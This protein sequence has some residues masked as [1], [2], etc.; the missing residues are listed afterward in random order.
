MSEVTV[1]EFVGKKYL[2]AQD[3]D[4]AFRAVAEALEGGLDAEN[5]SGRL[6]PAQL[7]QPRSL[8]SFSGKGRSLLMSEESLVVGWRL[9]RKKTDSEPSHCALMLSYSKKANA[10]DA[11]WGFSHSW[12]DEFGDDGL[13]HFALDYRGLLSS[14]GRLMQIPKGGW[15]TLECGAYSANIS[16]VTAQI[17]LSRPHVKG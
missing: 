16:Q 13:Q 6:G 4:A 3:L 11:T 8:Y 17:L 15:L 14:S 2:L 12:Q 1:P 7:A 5:F 10:P 9:Y